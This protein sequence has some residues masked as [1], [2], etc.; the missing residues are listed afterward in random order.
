MIKPLGKGS[1]VSKEATIDVG[2]LMLV[3]CGHRPET[4]PFE[5]YVALMTFSTWLHF[6]KTR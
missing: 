5:R 2:D 1:A 3:A 6:P 4:F